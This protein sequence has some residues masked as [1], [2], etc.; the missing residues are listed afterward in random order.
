MNLNY[1]KPVIIYNPNAGG[2]KAKKRFSL[3]YEFL[4]KEKL[5]ESIDVIETKNV[6]D[7]DDKVKEIH[8]KNQNDLIISIGGDGTI[9]SITNS[10]IKIPKDKR[11]PLFPLPSGSGDSLLRDF[12]IR[13]IKDAINN[14]KSLTA[15]KEFDLLFVEKIGGDFKYYCIN[16]IGMGFVSD[17]VKDI[18]SKGTK[19][20][21]A[22]GY[23]ITIFTAIGNFKPYNT[24]L[25]FRDQNGE[26]KEFKSEKVYF[27]TVS[28]TKY[29]GGGIMVAPEAKYN[30]GLMD[31]IV[32]YEI[33]RF[34][35]LRGFLKTFKGKHIKDKGCLYL[36]TDYLEIYSTPEFELMPDG[37]LFGSSPIRIS[38]K[39]KEISL[40]V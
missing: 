1:K 2:G 33:N 8:S 3:Y 21:G 4:L 15:P 12:K 31:I 26:M 13:S 36:K 10:L 17:V 30:D 9:S 16:V 14:Y 6:Q 18:I 24:V 22:F 20:L 23:A 25:K 28:N 7:V 11:L 32:L 29:T 19:K 38:I 27:L 39:P 5:F 34:Q 35:F 37:E 40:V